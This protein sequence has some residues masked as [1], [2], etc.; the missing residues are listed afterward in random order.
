MKGNVSFSLGPLALIERIEQEF[1]FFGKI[2]EW[3][4]GKAKHLPETTKLLIYNKLCKSLSVSKLKN[5]ILMNFSRS[6]D[7]EKNQKKETFIEVW[8]E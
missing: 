4:D 5:S 8:K 6:L 7:L 3:L 1:N 2:L